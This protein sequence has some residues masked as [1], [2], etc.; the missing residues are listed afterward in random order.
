MIKPDITPEAIDRLIESIKVSAVDHYLDAIAALR[1][2]SARV[3]ELEAENAAG[4]RREKDANER[5]MKHLRRAENAEIASKN[6]AAFSH[7]WRER[8]ERAEAENGILRTEKHADAEAIA[9]ARN[10]ALREAA[11]IVD[12]RKSV[13]EVGT[14]LSGNIL[15]LIK[16]PTT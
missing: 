1:T 11:A 5:A 7:E 6:H 4:L 14:E 2:Q 3:A 9:S 15:A 13:L 12:A 16:E 8:A 10:D